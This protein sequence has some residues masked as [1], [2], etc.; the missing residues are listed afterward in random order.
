[1]TKLEKVIKG[2]ECCTLEKFGCPSQDC[3][4]SY[5]KSD[6]R[7]DCIYDLCA[8]ALELLKAKYKPRE[9]RKMLPC[10]CGCKIREHWFSGSS[11]N[12][13]GLKCKK[14]GFAVWGKDGMDVIRKWNEVVKWND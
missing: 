2:L 10:K 14:C 7:G 4:Y 12:P 5:A 11:D 6:Y 1:M 13:E 9:S 3:P 8:D